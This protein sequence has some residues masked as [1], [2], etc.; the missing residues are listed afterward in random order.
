M[1]DRSFRELLDIFDEYPDI[2]DDLVFFTADTHSPLPLEKMHERARILSDRIAL[3]RSRGYGAGINILATIG[4]HSENLAN[5]LSGDYGRMVNIMGETAPGVLCPNDE[6]AQEYIKQLYEIIASC[7]PDHVWI[8]DD[9]RYGHMP[10]GNGCFCD[11]CL[12]IFES[13]SGKLYTRESLNNAFNKESDAA[14]TLRKLWL[15][16]NR[17]TINRLF[18]LIEHTVHS[19]KPDMPLGFM[20]G[21]R[22]YEGYDFDRWAKTLSGDAK[23]DVYWRPGGGFYSDDRMSEMAGKSHDI[24]RQVSVL[25]DDVFRIQAE[26]ESFPHQ[27][28]KKSAHVT[29]LE[30]ASYMASGCTGVAFNVLN[31]GYNPKAESYLSQY[32]TILK[33]I[34]DTRPFYNLLAG[35]LGRSAPQGLY[36]GWNKDSFATGKGDW[37]NCDHPGTGPHA[38]E[39]LELGLPAAYSF[40]NAQ[41]TLLTG[42][43][44]LSMDHETI[45]SILSRGVYMD[46]EA[47]EC[48]NS[49]G[50]GHL[51]GF[52][53]DGYITQDGIEEFTEHPLNASLTLST[54]DCRQ[55]F[56]FWL[57]P[58]AKLSPMA[59]SIQILAQTVDYSGSVLSPCCMGIFENSLGGRICVAGYYPWSYVQDYPKSMQIKSVMRWLSKDSIPAYVSSFH[60]VNLWARQ[61]SD[62]RNAVI[63]TNSSHDHV[64]DLSIILHTKS[65]IVSVFDMSCEE[66]IISASKTFGDYKEFILPTVEP[67]QMRLLIE[68]YYRGE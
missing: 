34:S 20:A 25:P 64:D 31:A 23:Y 52:S 50:F 58:A 1:N 47:L 16:H 26:I 45:Q 17:D 18:E 24:G 48:L 38:N 30:A 54:R 12:S 56:L 32:E 3:T 68:S 4:H 35:A 21:D 53:V 8:D 46:A 59:D 61:T 19:V 27:P 41:V 49:L 7:D 5:S 13:E 15:R 36:T 63:I 22:F 67:W 39:I 55:S 62:G 40:E 10:I 37:L 11:K 14:S 44:P 2:T 6:H 60:K 51:T 66:T 65:E 9:I 43:S 33:K 42:D 28:L 29:A 57:R